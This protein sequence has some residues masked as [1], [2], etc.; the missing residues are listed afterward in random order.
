MTRL[1]TSIRRELPVVISNRPLIIEMFGRYVNLRLKGQREA[2]PID[3][4]SIFDLARKR[5]FER[6]RKGAA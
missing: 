6:K 1:A 3:Y 4:E 2:F 5:D